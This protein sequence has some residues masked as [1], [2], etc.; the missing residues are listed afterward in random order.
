MSSLSVYHLSTAD[1]PNKLLT[2]TEDITRTLA[3]QGVTFASDAP[4]IDLRPGATE[5][6]VRALPD[7]PLQAS[8]LL[9]SVAETSPERDEWRAHWR[10][11]RVSGAAEQFV[12][13]GGRALVYLQ[14]GEYVHGLLCEKGDHLHVPA[15]T[16]YWLD[17]GEHPRC[18]LLHRASQP[19][20]PGDNALVARFPE[21]DD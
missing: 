12:L 5:A 17:I 15:G 19:A 8:D 7:S 20:V 21:L 6:E 4:R 2:H 18:L 13:L 14:V 9:L 16:P 10:Q 1:L 3:E 11:V